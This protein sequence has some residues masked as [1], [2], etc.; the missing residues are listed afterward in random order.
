M[1][2]AFD[3]PGA[4]SE[5]SNCSS[6]S[7][8][9]NCKGISR[10]AVIWGVDVSLPEQDY[11]RLALPKAQFWSEKQP[12]GGNHSSNGVLEIGGF[13][14]T[15]GKRFPEMIWTN[16]NPFCGVFT[17]LSLF[18]YKFGFVFRFSILERHIQDQIPGAKVIVESI[19]PR[20]H[21]DGF[22]LE[23]YSKSDLM[24]YA[25]DPL[26]NRAI[27]PKELFKWVGIFYYKK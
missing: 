8:R 12:D 21:G 10:L 16:A 11:Q 26:T 15:L 9:T 23:D 5:C 24:V 6:T 4:I 17:P 25:I 7:A 1:H 3:D 19:G 2:G 14:T 27:S 20:R 18:F 22:E 13:N